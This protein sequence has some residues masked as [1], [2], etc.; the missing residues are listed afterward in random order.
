MTCSVYT[1]GTTEGPVTIGANELA[2]LSFFG[3]PCS[4]IDGRVLATSLT[5]STG[6]LIILNVD[7]LLLKGGGFT[8][9]RQGCKATKTDRLIRWADKK[10]VILDHLSLG[11]FRCQ[12]EAQ[13][14]SPGTKEQYLRKRGGLFQLQVSLQP[15]PKLALGF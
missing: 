2:H 3:R 1:L 10:S 4:S 15:F 6:K 5:G 12:S 9:R 14:C 7:V 8:I 11:F 13:S